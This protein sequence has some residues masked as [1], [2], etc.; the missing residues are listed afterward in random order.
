MTGTKVEVYGFAGWIT[1]FVT[2]GKF[3]LRISNLLK[4]IVHIMELAS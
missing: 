2:F 1:T 3:E 4:R